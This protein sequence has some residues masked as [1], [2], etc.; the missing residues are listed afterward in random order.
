MLSG[1]IGTI[2]SNGC[3]DDRP[4]SMIGLREIV[5]LLCREWRWVAAVAVLPMLA[6]AALYLRATP[7]FESTASM[8]VLN[9]R[10]FDA[11]Y[12]ADPGAG[13]SSTKQ[14]IINSEIE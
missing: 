13:P 12:D 7:I 9:G 11:A 14:E 3:C 6:A 4:A 2:A 10:E 5:A 1:A 8:L